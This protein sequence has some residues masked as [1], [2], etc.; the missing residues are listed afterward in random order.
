MSDS[1]D[2]VDSDRRRGF[3]R[4]NSETTV[5]SPNGEAQAKAF[6][7]LSRLPTGEFAARKCSAV[8]KSQRTKWT[9]F[10]VAYLAKAAEPQTTLSSGP[11]TVPDDYITKT[12]CCQDFSSEVPSCYIV[13]FL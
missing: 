11:I 1:L 13:A 6:V 12:L 8:F 10:F 9:M 3:W 7:Q 4:Q 5:V 2:S